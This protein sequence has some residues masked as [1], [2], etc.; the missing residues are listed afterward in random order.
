MGFAT[1][2]LTCHCPPTPFSAV[3]L[4]PP[5]GTTLLQLGNLTSHCFVFRG[6]ALLLLLVGERECTMAP[7]FMAC[8]RLP[9]VYSPLSCRR[10]SSLPGVQARRI[11]FV[12]SM[13]PIGRAQRFYRAVSEP[14]AAAKGSQSDGSGEAHQRDHSDVQ[15]GFSPGTLAVHGG[16]R[17]GRPRVSGGWGR[18]LGGRG[19]VG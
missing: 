9:Q 15:A 17:A 14:V 12:R 3:P 19:V 18:W 5:T 13:R 11:P 16:E 6:T 8:S 4:R 2:A 7:L 1:Q 10:S